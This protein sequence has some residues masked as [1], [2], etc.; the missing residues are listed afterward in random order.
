[1]LVLSGLSC[2]ITLG[3]K[4]IFYVYGGFL[5]VWVVITLWRERSIH[6]QPMLVLVAL[7]GSGMLLPSAFWLLRAWQGTGN[8]LYP[9]QIKIGQHTIGKGYSP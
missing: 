5:L 4:P 3:T 2:G 1:M 9:I 7:V 6:R 8:P